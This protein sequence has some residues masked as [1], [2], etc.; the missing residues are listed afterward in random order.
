MENCLY[1]LPI[2]NKSVILFIYTLTGDHFRIANTT[3][4]VIS[5]MFV[6]RKRYQFSVYTCFS[7]NDNAR[8]SNYLSVYFL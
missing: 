3:M 4:F 2:V 7:S 6:T 8:N 5:P 1:V